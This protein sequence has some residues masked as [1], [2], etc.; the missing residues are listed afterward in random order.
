MKNFKIESNSVQEELKDF[1]NKTQNKD[2]DSEN[3]NYFSD[4]ELQTIKVM[5]QQSF[6]NN[7][8]IITHSKDALSNELKQL[9]MLRA[10]LAEA[11]SHLS[12]DDSNIIE[13][14]EKNEISLKEIKESIDY[15]NTELKRTNKGFSRFD[16]SDEEMP[17]P[18]LELLKKVEPLFSKISDAL[19]KS[20]KHRIEETMKEDL[21]STLVAYSDQIGKVEL[22]EYLND[23]SFKIY[24][25]AGNEI[26]LEELNAASKQIIVQVLLKSLHQFGD[27]NPPVMIDTVMG[28]LDEDSRASLLENY[29]PKLSHQ[30]ILLS[31]D[32][33]IRTDKDLDKIEEFISKKYTLVRDKENQFTVVKEGYFNS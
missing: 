17:N 4:D 7:F 18:R 15:I 30:T 6:I 8:N 5:L 33:E 14:Y 11:K 22:S 16:I 32:S 25:K 28:Y 26:Y 21:N 2:D 27:Y 3:F 19:L 9:P 13:S 31:T 1:F 10:E 23:L 24:H 20:K 12:N 29:F